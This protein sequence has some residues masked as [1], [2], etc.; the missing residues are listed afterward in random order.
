VI[1]RSFEAGWDGEAGGIFRYVAPE[2]GAPV[3]D[4]VGA[5]EELIAHSWS[6]KIWWPHSETLYAT[7][8]AYELTGDDAMRRLHDKAFGYTFATFPHPERSVGEWI[9]IRDRQG[10][11]LQQVVGL[12]V[13]D[14]YHLLRNLMLIVELLQGGL[15]SRIVRA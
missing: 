7:L 6:T 8:L 9:Q 5:F 1:A 4:P 11:P 2:G 3:G 12:P 14:P 10:R 13:K 15:E